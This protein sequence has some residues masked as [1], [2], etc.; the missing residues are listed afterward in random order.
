MT[1]VVIGN[2]IIAEVKPQSIHKA[3][4]STHPAGREQR[5]ATSQVYRPK[6]NPSIPRMLDAGSAIDYG[7]LPMCQ[8]S[9]ARLLFVGTSHIISAL[10]FSAVGDFLSR[11]Q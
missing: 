7:C 9:F 4:D 11:R 2:N 5:L 3:L 10:F 6:Q 8:V 1:S